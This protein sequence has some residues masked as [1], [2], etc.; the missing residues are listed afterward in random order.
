MNALA[1][2][3]QR[4]PLAIQ[5]RQL[6]EGQDVGHHAGHD[7]RNRRAPGHLDDRRVA[8]IG[9]LVN[10]C[11]PGRVGF[12]RLDTAPGGAGAPGDDGHGVLRGLSQL[13]GIGFAGDDAGHATGLALVQTG[14]ALAGENVLA[15]V[16]LD[17]LVDDTLGLMTRR[18]HDGVVVVERDHRQDDILGQRMR[19][20]DKGLR[21]T[22]TLQSM[23]PEHRYARLVFHGMRDLRREARP[24]AHGRGRQAA[25]F[26]KAA[27]RN[28]LT[29]HHI[30][31]GFNHVRTP[32]V[33]WPMRLITSC[34]APLQWLCHSEESLLISQLG[35]GAAL[36]NVRTGNSC[37]GISH[38]LESELPSMRRTAT[39]VTSQ[40]VRYSAPGFRSLLK[41]QGCPTRTIKMHNGENNVV[42][43]CA[44]HTLCST[45]EKGGLLR[46]LRGQPT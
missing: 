8:D 24:Q 46:Y 14:I 44:G 12:G 38:Q 33:S 11:R 26:Q 6:A 34:Q 39:P 27:A 31:E 7:L 22:G 23:Q 2:E 10:R 36:E 21:A 1:V 45:R 35:Q 40:H 32:P 25:E 9:N 17:H 37:G 43:G 42:A 13:L 5:R 16:L 29:A 4:S 30:V 41:L 18:R 3:H 15:L 20:T 19:R 28:T